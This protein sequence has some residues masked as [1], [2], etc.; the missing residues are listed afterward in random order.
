MP[1]AEGRTAARPE[2]GGLGISGWGKE[3]ERGLK[4]GWSGMREGKPHRHDLACDPT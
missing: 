2:E 4:L 3:E 1:Q